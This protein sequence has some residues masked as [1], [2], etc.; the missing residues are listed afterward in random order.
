[1]DLGLQGKVAI[2]TGGSEGIGRA[3]AQSLGR[4][5]ARVVVCGRRVDVLER[6][7]AKE[8]QRAGYAE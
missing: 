7:A 8:M 4:E 6:A 2:I 1:M 3:A 5:G